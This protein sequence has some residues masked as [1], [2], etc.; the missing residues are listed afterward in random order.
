M[1][2]DSKTPS[3]NVL[4]AARSSISSRGS[5]T[6]VF[7]TTS[8]RCFAFLRKIQSKEPR[9]AINEISARMYSIRLSTDL[10]PTAEIRVINRPTPPALNV[11]RLL[12]CSNLVLNQAFTF[13]E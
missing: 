6:A 2:A 4:T 8:S 12:S 9:Q 13:A 3:I 1:M 11:K 7:F 10:T 5:L